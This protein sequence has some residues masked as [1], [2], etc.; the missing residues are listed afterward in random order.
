MNVREMAMLQETILI[1][2]DNLDLIASLE[3][4]LRS[5]YNIIKARD[6]YQGLRMAQSQN[7][8][9]ILLDMNMPRMSG[10]A[11]L[12]ALNEI[13]CDVPVIFMTAAGSEDLA[14]RAF[15]L[16]VH[17][18]LIKP[19]D[20]TVLGESIDR[21]LSETR[22][23]RDKAE[24]EVVLATA[25]TVRQTVGTLAHHINNQLTV[26]LGGLT[27]L[28]ENMN[29]PGGLAAYAS[30]PTIFDDSITSA[31]RIQAVL[32][33]MQKITDFELTTY[34][35]DIGILDINNAVQKELEL[36]QRGK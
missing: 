32:H 11:V 27:I 23:A 13:A 15:R 18:Y 25:D 31:E 21:A 1:V 9:L 24:L 12:A 20:G 22:L 29:Q 17:D 35:E 16:G 26:V 28:Q 34:H 33:V 14:A 8:D 10:T 19:L 3:M 5:K 7:P 30:A 6:G 36:I 2:D 4:L